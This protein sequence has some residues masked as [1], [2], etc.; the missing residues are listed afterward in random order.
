M[1]PPTSPPLPRAHRR[2]TE[3]NETALV[4]GVDKL[5]EQPAAP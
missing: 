4:A 1:Q 5:V 2:A 3:C